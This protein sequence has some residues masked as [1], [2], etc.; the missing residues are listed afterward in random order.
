MGAR[1]ELIRTLVTSEDFVEGPRAFAQKR[2][3]DWK[4]R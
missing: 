4:G 1:Y 2:K 3:P